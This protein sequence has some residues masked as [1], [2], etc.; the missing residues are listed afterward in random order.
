MA[1]AQL[2]GMTNEPTAFESITNDQLTGVTGGF[3]FSDLLSKGSAFLGI[4]KQV[5]GLFGG[6]KGKG[7]GGPVPADA[8]GDPGAE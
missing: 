8:G 5:M 2:L 1:A 3:D 7:K 4:A 6:H